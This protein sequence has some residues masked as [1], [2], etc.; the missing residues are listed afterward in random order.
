MIDPRVT[1]ALQIACIALTLV[2]FWSTVLV[3]LGLL[4]RAKIHPK[5]KRH[6]RFAVLICARNEERVIRLPVRSILMSAY[7]RDCRE[8]I[9]LADNCTD[10]T[11]AV[12]RAAGATV[13]EKTTPSRGKGDV[14]S[15]GIEQIQQ[16]G[17]FDAI[18]VFDAD[19]I[20]ARE[21]FDAM[22]DALNDGE[23]VVTGCRHA[24][25]A[26]ANLISGWYTIYWD[27]MNELSNR[28]RTNLGLSGKLTGTGFAFLLSALGKDGW[29]TRTMVEDVEF[30]VQGNL[31]GRRVAY[32]PAAHYADEQPVTAQYMWRQ[33]RRWATGGWQVVAHY[34]G[35]WLGSLFRHPSC[36]LFDSFFAIL[37]GMSVAFILLFNLLA[38]IFRLCCGE[39]LSI[40]CHFFFWI[41]GFIFVMGWFTAWASVALSQEKR[42]PKV[43]A[44]I[45]FP[46]FSLILS[47][48]VL[49]TLIFPTRAWKPIPHNGDST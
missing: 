31:V 20:I 27:M 8:V 18:A 2:F 9:V 19:N 48:S 42:R 33:L 35:P 16:R 24:S 15:W 32:V 11:A 26:R 28:V 34:F 21:W 23:S 5:S 25:N 36:R 30:T 37:T 49:V 6:L 17:T 1:F 10:K 38:L 39:P 7:P 47:A 12:A 43:W 4:C 14:L 41:F 29:H 45:L 3:L 13:W 44:I 46:I 40:A 22:N